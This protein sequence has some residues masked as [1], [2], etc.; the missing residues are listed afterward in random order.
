[1]EELGPFSSVSDPDQSSRSAL[2]PEACGAEMDSAIAST[3]K[4][5]SEREHL[6]HSYQSYPETAS[7]TNCCIKY[8]L[9]LPNFLFSLLGF[10]LLSI[11]IWGL[12]D[13]ESLVSE[14]IG[15]LGTDPMLIFVLVGLTTSAVAFSGCIGAL[16]EN[17]CLLKFFTV[18]VITVVILEVFTGITVYTLRKQIKDFLEGTMLVAV[19]RYQDDEDL[20]FIIDEIQQG[21]QCCGVESYQDW[22]LNLYFNC[23]SPGVQACGVPSSCC[24]HSLENGTITNSQCGFGILTMEEVVAQNI[25]YLGGCMPELIR[26]IN[27]NMGLASSFMAILLAAEVISLLCA[28]ELLRDLELI[29]M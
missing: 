16:R 4:Q 24:I 23:S 9:F 20:R 26:W 5:K 7:L 8:V 22:K 18:S 6:L 17:Y 3:L 25:I 15:H 12:I 28:S 2:S 29:K 27:M 11:G 10:L 1:M 21:V 13:K 14:K 19:K